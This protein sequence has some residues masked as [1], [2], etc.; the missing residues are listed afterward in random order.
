VSR[1]D[2]GLTPS[3][4]AGEN[5]CVVIKAH[6]EWRPTCNSKQMIF[7]KICLGGKGQPFLKKMAFT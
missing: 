2:P 7:A 6:G 1:D 5:I 4:F 3:V